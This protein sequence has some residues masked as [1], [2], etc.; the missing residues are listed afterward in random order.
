MNISK[1]Q[2]VQIIN[3][4][5]EQIDRDSEIFYFSDIAVAIA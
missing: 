2:F 3:A 4:C 1:E 5:I